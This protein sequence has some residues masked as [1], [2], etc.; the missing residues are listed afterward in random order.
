MTPKTRVEVRGRVDSIVV[1]AVIDTGFDGEISLPREVAEKLGLELVGHETFELA[2]GTQV[3]ELI[4]SGRARLSGKFRN[5]DILVAN[6][7]ETLIGTRLLS[8][9]RLII[10]FKTGKVQ[11]AR[12][13]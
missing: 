5:V 6:T 9:C 7:Q 13:E 1:D 3:D 4:F 8:D 12:K 2:D 10:D 11:I